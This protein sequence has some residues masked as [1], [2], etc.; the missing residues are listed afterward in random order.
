MNQMIVMIYN[1]ETQYTGRKIEY[2]MDGNN[3]NN[4]NNEHIEHAGCGDITDDAHV[5]YEVDNINAFASEYSDIIHD[6]YTHI[7]KGNDINSFL[8]VYI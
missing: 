3:N 7:T 5:L 6:L 8:C 2:S 1:Q 4:N